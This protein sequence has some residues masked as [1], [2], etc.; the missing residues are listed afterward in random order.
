[1]NPIMPIVGK[2]RGAGLLRY[3]AYSAMSVVFDNE[4]FPDPETHIRI[5]DYFFLPPFLYE[6]GAIL[7]RARH[8]KIEV[9]K[10]I[11]HTTRYNEKE[12]ELEID[13]AI[14]KAKKRLEEHKGSNSG[15]EPTTI[16]YLV[17]CTEILSK[18]YWLDLNAKAEVSVK[19]IESYILSLLMEGIVFGSIFPELTERM[20]RKFYDSVE[21]DWDTWAPQDTLAP[22]VLLKHI[23]ALPGEPTILSL[24][25]QE[26]TILQLVGW[27]TAHFYPELI[28]S[29]DLKQYCE[30]EALVSHGRYRGWSK[31]YDTLLFSGYIPPDINLE[32][33]PEDEI[34]KVKRK[35][36][37]TYVNRNI[38]GRIYSLGNRIGNKETRIFHNPVC[39]KARR[40]VEEKSIWF[41]ST[42]DAIDAE[43]TSCNLCRPEDL[44]AWDVIL[45]DRRRTYNRI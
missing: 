28:D 32:E 27:Y 25:G 29:L 14:Y 36:D 9:I 45:G 20:N 40:M 7:G 15:K 17:M 2:G 21:I 31:V 5:S 11:L 6:T 13:E 37:S 19:D 10:K 23:Y 39:H 12:I 34:P 41:E 44:H 33:K 3:L 22:L 30:D 18:T 16:F 42:A 38:G 24:E 8:D 43:Y 35:S 1:M 4:G 26:N